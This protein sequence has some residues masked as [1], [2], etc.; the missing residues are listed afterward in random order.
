MSSGQRKKKAD[1][2]WL[3]GPTYQRGR[4][5][6]EVPIRA[7]W[8]TGSWAAFQFGPKDCP[9]SFFYIFCVS[10]VFLFLFSQLFY[11]FFKIA[12]IEPKSI[13]NFF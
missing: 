1:V 11:I 13:Y 7:G 8:G 9:A 6:E 2:A 12:R 5:E 4:R 10:F 3:A